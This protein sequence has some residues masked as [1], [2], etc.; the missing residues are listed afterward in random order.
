MIKMTKYYLAD[1]KKKIYKEPSFK[2]FKGAVR[3]NMMAQLYDDE[4]FFSVVPL[5]ETKILKLKLKKEAGAWV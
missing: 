1:I 3:I 2:T 4:K 5:E